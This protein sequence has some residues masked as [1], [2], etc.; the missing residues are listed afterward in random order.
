MSVQYL[1]WALGI[2]QIVRYRRR[3]RALIL[4]QG[5]FHPPDELGPTLDDKATARE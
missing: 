5:G 1:L 3:T 4:Q 2:V